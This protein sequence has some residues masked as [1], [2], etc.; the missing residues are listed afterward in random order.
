MRRHA[1]G[2]AAAAT[3]VVLLGGLTAFY[4]NRLATERDRAEL[5]AAKA[6]RV[7]ELLTSLFTSADPYSTPV[8]RGE[9][10]VRGLLDA[11]ADRVRKELVGQPEVQAEM[12]TVLGRIYRRLGAYDQAQPL[13]EQALVVGRPVFGP[14]NVRLAQTLNDLGILLSERG[15]YK[16]AGASLEEALNMRRSLLGRE[17]TDVAITLVELGRV[18]QDQGFNDR[19]EPLQR[20]AL[21]IR[22]KLLGDAHRETATSLS[23]LAS[24]LRLNGD[25]AGRGVDC[26]NC[27]WPPT[28][29]RSA[30][31]I[32][33][34]TR[35]CTTWRSSQARGGTIAQPSRCSARR[36]PAAARRS[37]SGIRPW[38]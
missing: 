23:D 32:R 31:I 8:T 25:L 19:A 9:P 10:T 13:L 27:V 21:A 12:L 2:V 30:R 5:E 6:A 28:S 34:R 18:Y 3:V 22:R 37:A 24:V 16:A 17:H 20:E 38:P 1:R 36:S 33:T 14:A 4:T 7:S 11:G 29:R 26:S 15:D 35:R